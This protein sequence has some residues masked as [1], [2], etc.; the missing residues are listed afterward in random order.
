M[1]PAEEGF[2]LV[3]E[4]RVQLD[5]RAHHPQQRIVVP[6][7]AELLTLLRASLAAAQL[8]QSTIQALDDEHRGP[9][10]SGRR[11]RHP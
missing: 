3:T 2:I 9:C 7:A 4:R 11:R 6:V 1:K 10:H 5:A 8:R